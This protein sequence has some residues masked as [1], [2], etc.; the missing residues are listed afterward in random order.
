MSAVSDSTNL[1]SEINSVIDS[2]VPV[3]E[4]SVYSGME[5]EATDGKIGKLD[6]LI[7]DPDS[8]DV[9]HI[10]MRKGHLWARRTSPFPMPT[11][12]SPMVTPSISIS[13]RKRCR[14]CPP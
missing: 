6:E 2:Q 1:S 5:V 10:Q 3:G 13:T 8:G 14:H 11:L 7:L 9:T 4:L 12:T